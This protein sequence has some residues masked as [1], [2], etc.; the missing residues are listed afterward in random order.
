MGIELNDFI[1]FIFASIGHLKRHFNIFTR[2]DG[3]AGKSHIR[4]FEC[5]IAQSVTKVVQCSGSPGLLS[6]R[7]HAHITVYL[8]I[9]LIWEV[10]RYL[11]HCL[12]IGDR[13]LS[14]RIVISEQSLC[15]S[16]TAMSTGIERLKDCI[17]IAVRP[18]DG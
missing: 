11:A 6:F 5:S 7:T 3:L 1:A 18:V 13:D 8:G 15:Y 17:G 10:V 16:C 2:H 12:R 4:I 9:R 14:S